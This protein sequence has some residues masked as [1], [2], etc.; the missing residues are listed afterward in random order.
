MRTMLGEEKAETELKIPIATKRT[1]KNCGG[2]KDMTELLQVD[3]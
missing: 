1:K 2:R 3:S